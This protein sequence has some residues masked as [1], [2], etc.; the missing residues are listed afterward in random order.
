MVR[1]EV[2]LPVVAEMQFADR[3]GNLVQLWAVFFNGRLLSLTYAH[4]P[5]F[6]TEN[7]AFNVARS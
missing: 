5:H 4:A 2:Q 7:V 3:A 1:Q 6:Q